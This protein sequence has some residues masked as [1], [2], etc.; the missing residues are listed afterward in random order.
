[1]KYFMAFQLHG[2]SK[3][4][5]VLE[6][7]LYNGLISGLGLDGKSFFYTN[8]ME[9]RKTSTHQHL[10]AERAGWFECSCCPT[11]LTRLIPSVP[12]YMYATGD[13]GI[14]INLFAAS[15]SKL[16]VKGKQVT[17]QQENNYPWD[18]QLKFKVDPS[19]KQDFSIFL[20]IPGWA[21]N[22]IVPSN[23]Y[24]TNMSTTPVTISINGKVVQYDVSKGYAVLTKTWK[25]GD[26]VTMLLPMDIQKV[27]ANNKL[28]DDIGKIA[29]QRGPIVYCAEWK[30]NGGLASNLVLARNT[31]LIPEFR[32]D[33]LNG[34][35]ILKGEASAIAVKA[36]AQTVETRKQSFVA[37]PY[38]AW[39]NRGK[40]EMLIWL[41]EK[42]T[43]IDLISR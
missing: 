37:I 43:G 22:Q 29:L 23:L 27:T 1:M 10:E 18:G 41:P 13:R 26:V 31:K 15:T 9:V 30:D 11:N 14:Y 4:I 33:L 8:A 20:R 32:A 40:G 2:E 28:A 36:D 5:D 3:Y 38:Y 16:A 21:S 24:T 25:K 12:G 6:R 39:A 42:L 17:I 7:S 19:I 35:M 34:V